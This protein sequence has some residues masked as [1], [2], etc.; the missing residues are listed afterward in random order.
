MTDPVTFDLSRLDFE[1]GGG[2]VTVVTQDARSGCVLMTARAD[3]EAVRRTV[4]TGEMH[5]HSRTRGLW[6]KGATSGN[7]QRVVSLA[8]DCDGDA[9]LARVHPMGPACHAGTRSCFGETDG[10]HESLPLAALVALDEIIAR[11]ATVVT[12]ASETRTPSSSYTERLLRDRNLRL[13]KL[14]EEAAE[15]AVAC[16]DG[17]AVQARTEGADLLY[18]M[19][20]ALRSIGVNLAD[21]AS[22]L[23]ERQRARIVP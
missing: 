8:V 6:H 3:R 9:L 2:F 13:K 15:L 11:R 22:V 20:V 5:Y 16:A 10:A 18:H 14:G 17:D 1:A 21:V 12:P 4:T 7:R 19:L 23:E